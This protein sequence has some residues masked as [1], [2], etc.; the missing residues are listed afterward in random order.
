[1]ARRPSANSING[2]GVTE[3]AMI[4]PEL[5]NKVGRS[6]ERGDRMA[7]AKRLAFG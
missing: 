1:M 4:G 5:A 6:Q 2:T 7:A 3:I